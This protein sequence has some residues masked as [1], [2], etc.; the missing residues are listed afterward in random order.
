MDSEIIL[1][2]YTL[3]HY[4]H[5]DIRNAGG[6]HLLIKAG[7]DPRLLDLTAPTNECSGRAKFEAHRS[8]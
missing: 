5:V 7:L 2:R 8:L 1:P 3:F 6:V 4:D